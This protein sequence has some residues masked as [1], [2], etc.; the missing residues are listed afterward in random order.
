MHVAWLHAHVFT[1]KLSY[2]C[3][4]NTYT[5]CAG[6]HHNRPTLLGNADT[7]MYLATQSLVAQ[8]HHIA[9]FLEILTH[10]QHILGNTDMFW[11]IPTHRHVLATQSLVAQEHHKAHIMIGGGY[12]GVVMGKAVYYTSLANGVS[13]KIRNA[14]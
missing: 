5:S 13:H 8:E 12:V 4:H 14:L 9:T 11:E 1:I 7:D 6:G 10:Y 2:A 3:I